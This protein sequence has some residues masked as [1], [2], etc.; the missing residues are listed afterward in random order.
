MKTLLIALLSS[1]LISTSV[2]YADASQ[3]QD[4]VLSSAFKTMLNEM[5]PVTPNEVDQYHKK[6]MQQEKMPISNQSKESNTGNVNAR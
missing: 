1:A 3:G 2:M 4:P 6:L 5:Y